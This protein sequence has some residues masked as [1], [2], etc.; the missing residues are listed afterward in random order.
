[1]ILSFKNIAW[2]AVGLLFVG[3]VLF[4]S[5]AFG[6]PNE[7][8]GSWTFWLKSNEAGLT[9]GLLIFAGIGVAYYLGFLEPKTKRFVTP[10]SQLLVSFNAAFESLGADEENRPY[11]F[12]IYSAL[13]RSYNLPRFSGVDLVTP[14]ASYA[15]IFSLR[16]NEVVPFPDWDIQMFILLTAGVMPS[17][18]ILD[19]SRIVALMPWKQMLAINKAGKLGDIGY[20]VFGTSS[21]RDVFNRL[22]EDNP[23]LAQDVAPSLMQRFETPVVKP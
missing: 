5:G 23:D 22:L 11:D 12:K 4:A 21:T 16:K 8:F 9:I 10:P 3:A 15:C 17:P 20:E 2:G 18:Y 19:G 7:L 6:S 1:M 13:K 14:S